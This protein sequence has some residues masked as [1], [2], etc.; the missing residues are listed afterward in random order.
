MRKKDGTIVRAKMRNLVI[1]N[2]GLV[3]IGANQDADMVIAK[4]AALEPGTVGDGAHVIRIVFKEP[5]HA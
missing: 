2:L 1:E 5:T 4:R 3:D